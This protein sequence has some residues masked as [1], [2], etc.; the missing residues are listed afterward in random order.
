MDDQGGD[1]RLHAGDDGVID[2]GDGR[3]GT[4]TDGDREVHR[5]RERKRVEWARG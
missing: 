2:P 4:E 1:E 3:S 5:G